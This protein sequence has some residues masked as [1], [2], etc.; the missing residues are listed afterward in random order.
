MVRSDPI[1]LIS[2]VLYLPAG[3]LYLPRMGTKLY[4]GEPDVAQ[5]KGVSS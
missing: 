4:V 3:A 5:Q 2:G 1:F